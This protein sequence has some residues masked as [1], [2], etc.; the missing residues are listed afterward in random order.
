MPQS[1]LSGLTMTPLIPAMVIAALVIGGIFLIIYSARMRAQAVARRVET[2]QS[3]LKGSAP[4]VQT[5]TLPEGYQFKQPAGGLPAP[6]QQQVARILL[7]LNISPDRAVAYFTG[8]RLMLAAIAGGAVFAGVS[9]PTELLESL[10]IIVAVAAGWYLPLIV[11][12]RGLKKHRK[13]VASALPDA[14]ELLA[15]CVDAGISLEVGLNRIGD[16]L[17]DAQPAL[18]NELRLTWAEI[19]LLPSLDQALLNLAERVNHQG[20]RSV[21]GTLAQSLRFGTPLAQSLRVAAAEMR[22]DQL[23]HLEEQANRLPALLTVPVMLL[24]MPTIFLIVGGPATLK[25]LD[26]V[27]WGAH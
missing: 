26:T 11:V 5:R 2:V 15:I 7:N 14:L 12:K 10:A 23:C 13:N 3:L 25:I 8:F 6:E 22:N 20:F 9:D 16:E 1:L 21:V 19:T 17:R 27:G 18:A 24:I 4:A